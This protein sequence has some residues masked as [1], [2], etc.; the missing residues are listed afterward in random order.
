MTRKQTVKWLQDQWEQS[1]IISGILTMAIW[2]TII[3]LT[4]MGRDPPDVLIGAGGIIIGFFFRAKKDN[5]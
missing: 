2:G 3:A 1:N 5:E 4:L